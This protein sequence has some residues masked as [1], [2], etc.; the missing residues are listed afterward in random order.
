MPY[1]ECNDIN[2]F[3]TLKKRD[4]KKLLVQVIMALFAISSFSQIEQFTFENNIQSNPG[5]SPFITNPDD[6]NL[7]WKVSH[8]TPSLADTNGI[9]QWNTAVFHGRT[10]EYFSNEKSDGI[11]LSYNFKKNHRYDIIVTVCHRNGDSI[12]IDLYATNNLSAK[13]D[14]A[15]SEEE[16]PTV[17]DKQEIACKLSIPSGTNSG[18]KS[19]GKT[20]WV[21]TKDFS[22]IW[23]KSS[24]CKSNAEGS[25]YMSGI[26][27]YER[28]SLKEEL[29]AIPCD[30]K[31]SMVTNTSIDLSWN[32]SSDDSEIQAYRIYRNNVLLTTVKNHSVSITGLSSC[33]IYTLSVQAVGN[34]GKVSDKNSITVSTSSD[35]DSTLSFDT[36]LTNEVVSEKKALSTIYLKNGFVFKPIDESYLFSARIID[37]GCPILER[38]T[39][40]TP[41][42]T[43]PAII[44]RIEGSELLV[45]Y[46]LPVDNTLF[47][48][49]IDI[50]N[51]NILE[52]ISIEGDVVEKIELAGSKSVEVGHLKPDLYYIKLINNGVSLFGKFLKQ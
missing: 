4:M 2:K 22:Q 27:I 6:F 49:N 38:P 19:V 50:S 28:D 25:F 47:I 32:A 51:G 5:C 3:K 41:K 36:D 7:E 23:I 34:N 48:K 11:F 15:C 44:S 45:L 18:F 10:S 20:K 14:I 24:L 8:G 29:P 1:A 52:I 12:N 17:D 33:T 39:I 16:A 9:N 21:A 43:E 13:T 30:L 40:K 42:E 31:S 46:P 37:G 35:T 26:K